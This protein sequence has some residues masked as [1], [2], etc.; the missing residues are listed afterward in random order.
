[1]TS[2]RSLGTATDNPAGP[3]PG[4]GHGQEPAGPAGGTGG[5]GGVETRGKNM[6]D[7]TATIR[8]RQPHRPLPHATRRAHRPRAAGVVACAAAGRVGEIAARVSDPSFLQAC[9]ARYM[10]AGFGMPEHRGAA[11]GR[12]QQARG[13][14]LSGVGGA[15]STSYQALSQSSVSNWSGSATCSW[16]GSSSTEALSA[17]SEVPCRSSSP[18]A[19]RRPGRGSARSTRRGRSPRTP[20]LARSRARRRGRRA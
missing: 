12:G 5:C 8:A 15:T 1:M 17:M 20:G 2:T 14:D 10:A 6:S 16:T 3:L 18:R 11:S 4:A 13:R 19:C 9:A 7:Q